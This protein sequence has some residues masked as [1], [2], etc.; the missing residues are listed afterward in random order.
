MGRRDGN[1]RQQEFQRQDF[2]LVLLDDK[3]TAQLDALLEGRVRARDETEK[4]GSVEA[5][6]SAMGRKN[7]AA[8]A[9]P[10]GPD[11]VPVLPVPEHQ[12]A[13]VS[14]VGIGVQGLSGAFSDGAEGL[15]PEPVDFLHDGRSILRL[16]E[17]DPVVAGIEEN[18]VPEP[19]HFGADHFGVHVGCDGGLPLDFRRGFVLLA[20]G[21]QG[22]G[23]V[24]KVP[25]Q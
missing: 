14:I 7:L 3:R 10:V 22:V 20:L 18:L 9:E 4:G 6:L 25:G 8:E 12:M 19:V 2:P 11:D 13:V 15:L 16:D 5:I 23:A 21:F 17:E 1:A 24:A